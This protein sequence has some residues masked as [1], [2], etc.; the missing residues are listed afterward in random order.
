MPNL[1]GQNLSMLCHQFF[2]VF[3]EE[4]ELSNMCKSTLAYKWC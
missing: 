2:A 1:T 3:P 4:K